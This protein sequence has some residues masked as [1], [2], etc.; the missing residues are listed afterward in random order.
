MNDS[1]AITKELKEIEIIS[2]ALHDIMIK[3]CL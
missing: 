3:Q 2:N 1:T